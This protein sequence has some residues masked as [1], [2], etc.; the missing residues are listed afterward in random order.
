MIDAKRS[1]NMIRKLKVHVLGVVEN[2][3]G[4]VFGKGGGEELAN[5]MDLTFL[6]RLDMRPDYRDTSKPTVLNS[7]IVLNEFK[8]IADGV[9]GGLEST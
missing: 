5:D 6:G 9:K 2:F 3:A 7:N 8:V 1:I 4:E